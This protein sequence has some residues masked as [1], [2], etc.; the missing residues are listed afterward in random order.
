MWPYLVLKW[1]ELMNQFLKKYIYNIIGLLKYTLQTRA[2]WHSGVKAASWSPIHWRWA[3]NLSSWQALF[4][5]ALVLESERQ[6]LQRCVGS[7][8]IARYGLSVVIWPKRN[9]WREF[10][11]TL[12]KLVVSNQ[13]VKQKGRA[14]KPQQK[15]KHALRDQPWTRRRFK[16]SSI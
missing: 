16:T 6:S 15:N 8:R 9:I 4:N 13:V 12:N 2:T 7:S 11:L 3:Q 5:W 1:H 14:Q 10:S